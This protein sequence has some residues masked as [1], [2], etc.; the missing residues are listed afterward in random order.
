MWRFNPMLKGTKEDSIPVLLK[1]VSG[2]N[3]QVM[4][5]VPASPSIR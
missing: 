1:N 2:G 3:Y 4:G 5:E